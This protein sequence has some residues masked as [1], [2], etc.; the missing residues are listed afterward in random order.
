[1][2]ASAISEDATNVPAFGASVRMIAPA[3]V[4]PTRGASRGPDPT[5]T[6]EMN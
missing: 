5:I 3:I 2:I 6:K 1:M 4:H